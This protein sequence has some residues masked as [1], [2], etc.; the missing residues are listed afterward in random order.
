MNEK[1][2]KPPKPPTMSKIGWRNPQARYVP[3]GGSPQPTFDFKP[4][5]PALKIPEI[6]STKPSFSVEELNRITRWFDAHPE[7]SPAEIC[8][9]CTTR[10]QPSSVLLPYGTQA[11]TH[12][13]LRAE[14]W[15][16]WSQ[17]RRNKAIKAVIPK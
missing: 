2:P 16:A 17:A 12:T 11:G 3:D 15:P 7:P 13:W 4:T 10:E 1:K 14:C 8:A 5:P 6:S 9:W